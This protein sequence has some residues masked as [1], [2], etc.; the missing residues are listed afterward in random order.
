[1]FAGW[2]PPLVIVTRSRCWRPAVPHQQRNRQR[3]TGRQA[4]R[5]AG[6][7][8]GTS[9]HL[10]FTEIE[11]HFNKTS[12]MTP[13][14]SD[15]PKRTLHFFPFYSKENLMFC[16]QLPRI[17]YFNFLPCSVHELCHQVNSSRFSTNVD[18]FCT[19]AWTR[20]SE[21]KSKILLVY[22]QQ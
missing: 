8:A 10:C 21:I 13:L 7:Q 17:T 4:G 16:S 14:T 19:E 15:T 6:R 3:I 18:F 9:Q 22:I 20:T 12:C 11:T 1:M 2:S 5:K